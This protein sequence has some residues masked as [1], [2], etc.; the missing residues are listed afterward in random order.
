MDPANVDEFGWA[1]EGEPRLAPELQRQLVE[2]GERVAVDPSRLVGDD[3]DLDESDR[4]VLADPDLADQTQRMTVELLR[5]GAWGWVD[6]SLAFVQPW[7]FDVGEIAVPVRVTYGVTDVIVPAAHGEW[8]GRHIPG[9]EVVV[10]DGAGH[11]SVLDQVAPSMR[12]LVTGSW[13]A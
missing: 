3:W 8:L 2:L 11:L 13:S 9:A 4:A 6:D 1:V 10:D 7:G 5:G 12:W